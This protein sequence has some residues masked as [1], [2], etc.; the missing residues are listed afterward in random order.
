MERFVK[1]CRL[2]LIAVAISFGGW[3]FEKVG[4]YIVY[5]GVG[6]R[7]FLHLPLCPIYG[8]STALIFLLA[9]T[10]RETQGVVGRLITRAVSKAEKKRTQV[11]CTYA[12]YFVFV[13]VLSTVAELVTALALRPFGVV[14]WDYSERAFNF[15]GV[16]CL[17]F[18]LTWGALITLFMDTLWRPLMRVADRIAPRACIALAVP[19]G[20]TVSA[21]FLVRIIEMLMK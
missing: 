17:G 2:T 7:G 10:P 11:L 14:L 5:G 8:I 19:I 21:D 4:R 18:S 12:L 1:A 3:C 15:L 20:A 6:D 13:T 16:I 9:G